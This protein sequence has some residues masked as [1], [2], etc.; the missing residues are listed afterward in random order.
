MELLQLRYF[1]DCARF[2]SIVKTAKNIWF[3][4]RLFLRLSDVWKKNSKIGYLKEHLTVL[5]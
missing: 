3:L 4:R 5:S 1:Y 2:G